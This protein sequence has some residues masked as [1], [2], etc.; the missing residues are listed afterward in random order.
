MSDAKPYTDEE[1]E[2]RRKFPNVSR[3]GS[4]VASRWREERDRWLATV[5]ALRAE[6]ERCAR[7]AEDHACCQGDKWFGREIAEK[8]RALDLGAEKEGGQR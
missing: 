6:R 1:Q 7:V 5:D 2:Y 4:D 3:N 8:I